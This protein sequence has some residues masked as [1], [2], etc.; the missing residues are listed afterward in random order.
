MLPP[1]QKRKGT[2]QLRKNCLIHLCLA[3]VARHQIILPLKVLVDTQLL[4]HGVVLF[5]LTYLF[6]AL[7]RYSLE[8]ERRDNFT[9]HY[10]YYYFAVRWKTTLGP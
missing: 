7:I 2:F 6:G 5:I 4:L 1:C 10:Y 3:K 9:L 8:I